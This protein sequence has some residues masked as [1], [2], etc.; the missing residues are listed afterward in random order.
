MSLSPTGEPIIGKLAAAPVKGLKDA[1]PFPT[2]A[3]YFRA[4]G[5]AAINKYADADPASFS[6]ISARTCCE[7]ISKTQ[8]F[9]DAS[10]TFPLN[11]MDLGTQNI[12]ID[13]NFNFLAIIDWEFAQTAPWQ[14]NHYLMPFPLLQS[15]KEITEILQCPSHLAHNNVRRQQAARNLYKQSFQDAEE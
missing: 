14:V 9:E 4:V 11:H 12:L 1:G 8:L 2:A 6:R 3:A 5:Q 13:E 7:I 15:D 10:T